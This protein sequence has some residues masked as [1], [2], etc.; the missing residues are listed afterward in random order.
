M[1]KRGWLVTDWLTAIPN[2]KTFWHNL[3]DWFPKLEDKTG[4]YTDF[5]ILATKIESLPNR[6]DYIVRNGT[7]FRSMKLDVPTISLIQDIA[8][9]DLFQQQLDVINHS[10]V[11]I[12]N[13][14]YVYS[15]Y[16]DHIEKNVSVQIIP[17][18]IDFDLFKPSNEIYPGVLPNSLLYIGDSSIYPK[19]FDRMLNI[20]KIMPSQNFCLIMKDNF[21][22]EK[23]PSE[24]HHRVKIFNRVN[25]NTVKQIINSCIAAICTSRE[26]TQHLSGLE[27]GACNKPIISTC[28]G[29]YYDCQNDREWGVIADEINFCEKI[30]YVLNNLNTFQPRAY[31]QSKYSTSVCRKKWNDVINSL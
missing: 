15:K 4:G 2:T 5:S 26:E 31:F 1:D 17:L 28:V 22:I 27:C 11:V 13:S 21:S 6:P 14:E 9:G 16:K 10:K 12:F 25:T 18:G 20:I 23:I 7:Y 19:G 30:N 8:N 3:L 24:Y 29:I